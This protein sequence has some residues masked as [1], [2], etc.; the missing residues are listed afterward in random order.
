MIGQMRDR[1]VFKEPV[2]IPQPGAGAISVYQEAFNCWSSAE[3]VTE[4]RMIENS[5]PN[6]LETYTFIIRY[7]NFPQ[8][9]KSMLIE[10]QGRDFTIHNIDPFMHNRNRFWRITGVTNKQPIQPIIS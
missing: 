10:Y 2:D 8:P 1:I 7:R 5:Q 9:N 6:L 4:R 3:Q